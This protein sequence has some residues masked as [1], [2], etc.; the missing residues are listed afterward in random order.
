MAYSLKKIKGMIIASVIIATSSAQAY[1]N[2]CSAEFCCPETCPP[3]TCCGQFFFDAEAVY[4]RA[5]EGGLSGLCDSV[6]ITDVTEGGINVSTLTGTG[7]NPKFKW[8]WGYRLGIGSDLANTNWDIRTYWTHFDSKANGD[9]HQW[10]L[11]Y[12]VVDLVFLYDC[13]WSD[14]IRLT[15]YGGARYVEI[16]QKLHTNFLSTVDTNP[17]TSVGRIKQ[18]FSGVGPVLGLD[19]DWD[20]NCGFSVYGNFAVA[21]LYGSS[22]VRSD[23]TDT[24]ITGINI[25]HLR[26]HVQTY[27]YAVDAAVG[28]RWKTQFC[29]DK[30]LVLQFGLEDHRYFNHNQFSNCGD[31][32]LDGISFGA[33]VYY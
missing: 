25:N 3:E 7:R 8:D 9:T 33:S 14:C 23:Q 28:V 11:R 2:A 21:I 12:N 5:F 10:K 13:K 18:D 27:Q 6:Q 15:P 26:N 4:F 32:S 16:D 20:F 19:A 31:L 30:I 17:L 29:N 22:H 24:G 1:D